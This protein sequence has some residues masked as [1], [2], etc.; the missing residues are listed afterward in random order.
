MLTASR[1][2]CCATAVAAASLASAPAH[3]NYFGFN[4]I[5]ENQT[6]QLEFTSRIIAD[7]TYFAT[8]SIQSIGGYGGIQQGAGS[9]DHRGLFSL[10]DT[11]DVSRDSWVAGLNPFLTFMGRPD[12]RFD[13]EG[14]GSQLLFQFNWLGS[15]PYRMAWRRYLVPG[16]DKVRYSTFYHDPYSAGGWVWVGTFDKPQTTSGAQNMNG[17]ETFSEDWAGTGGVREIDVRNVWL[18]DL[19]D[20]WRNISHA[21][22]SWDT[23]DNAR[24]W[25]IPGGWRHHSYDPKYTFQGVDDLPMGADD[26]I[27]PIH[28]P[29]YINA[30]AN[31]EP[32]TDPHDQVGRSITQAFEPDAYWQGTSSAGSSKASIHIA[33]V[34]HAAP[35]RL[36]RDWREGHSFGYTLFGL[37]PGQPTKIRL[38][39]VEPKYDLAGARRQSVEINGKVVESNLDI[40]AAAGAR[41]RA[42]VRTYKITAGPD[43]KVV[44][45]L[46]ALVSGVPALVAGIEAVPQ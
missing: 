11:N 4:G 3:A 17:F 46:K 20:Q 19:K 44:I 25:A 41:N 5:T 7:N 2:L 38:H 14:T 10:W 37:P 36:Y 40:R 26:T 31:I 32:S 9:G 45:K 21:N 6:Y 22:M 16:S 13:G 39:F 27:A 28:I 18:L 35:K 12:H 23:R 43:G 8:M 34:H 33:G 24:L 29:Y 1:H 15:K 42:L 30:G